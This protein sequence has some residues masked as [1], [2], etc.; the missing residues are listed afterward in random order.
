MLLAI[1][2]G[3][4][5]GIACLYE[6]VGMLDGHT[7]VFPM[8]VGMTAQ[9]D[10]L[11]SLT[12]DRPPGSVRCFME[13][14][15][16]YRPGNSGPAACTFA[17]HVGNLEAALYC[18]GIPVHTV[19]PGV[20]MRATC[21]GLPKDKPERKK[22]IKEIMSREYPQLKVTLKTADALGILRYALRPQDR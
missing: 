20:W 12:Q 21:A 4:S 22:R 1:D 15:G 14:V 6:S 3:A 18:L 7:E 13:N 10:L 16:G 17:R 8:P 2:P 5:G 9:V 11:R 19:A